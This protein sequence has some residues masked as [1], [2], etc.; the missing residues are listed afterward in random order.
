VKTSAPLL[1]LLL[2]LSPAALHAADPAGDVNGDAA[3]AKAVVESFHE[4]LLESMKQADQLGFQG[5][6]DLVFASLP[7]AFDLPFMARAAIGATW[8]QLAAQQRADFVALSRRFSAARYADNFD[9]YAGQHFETRAVEPSARATFLVKT[10][11]VQPEDED[12]EFDYRLRAV[13]GRW[14]II[15]VLLDGKISELA[16]L[17]GQYQSVIERDGFEELLVA[18][19][20]KIAEH[21]AQ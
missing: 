3:A 18:I 1:T 19:E 9:G 12:V 13:G 2:L 7:A 8:Q 5:R 15:D 10:A 14:R 16:L 6:Y 17:R 11:F 20:E 4:A 21:A